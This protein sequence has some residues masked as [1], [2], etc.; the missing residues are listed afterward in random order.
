MQIQLNEAVK[1]E[2][3]EGQARLEKAV[4]KGQKTTK[5]QMATILTFNNFHF[6]PGW[7]S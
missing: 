7:S 3:V 5:K 4:L 2:K 1:K 6:P